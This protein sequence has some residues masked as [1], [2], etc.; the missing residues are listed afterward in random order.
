MNLSMRDHC[1]DKSLCDSGEVKA[2]LQE[3]ERVEEE[4]HFLTLSKALPLDQV[5]AAAIRNYQA[6]DTLRWKKLVLQ[7]IAE[8]QQLDEEE[9]ECT[10]RPQLIARRSTRSS[11]ITCL[12]C[13]SSCAAATVNS[14]RQQRSTRWYH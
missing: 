5:Q 1:A 9:A 4:N 7:S 10:Y 2:R 11:V 6:A 12:P 3:D 14:T 13:R 8:Q